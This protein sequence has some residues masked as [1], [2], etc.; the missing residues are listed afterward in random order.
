M[1]NDYYWRYALAYL[2]LESIYRNK[3]FILLHLPDAIP[4]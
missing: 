2:F 4:V 1:A 3:E